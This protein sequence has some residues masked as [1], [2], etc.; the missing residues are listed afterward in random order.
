[1]RRFVSG[2]IYWIEI[3]ELPNG[4]IKLQ[5]EGKIPAGGEFTIHVGYDSRGRLR[6]GN[7]SGI[8]WGHPFEEV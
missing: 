5:R 8:R 2:K 7:S 1:M 3:A 4:L 6:R